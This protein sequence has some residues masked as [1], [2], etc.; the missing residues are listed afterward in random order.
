MFQGIPRSRREVEPLQQRVS[1]LAEQR[2]AGGENLLIVGRRSAVWCRVRKSGARYREGR[3]EGVIEPVEMQV[4]ETPHPVESS[5]ERG[6]EMQLFAVL[7][8]LHHLIPPEFRARN[9]RA[10]AT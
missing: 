2:F 5:A 7:A 8:V 4:E 10:R 6:R 1:G 9:P 3:V